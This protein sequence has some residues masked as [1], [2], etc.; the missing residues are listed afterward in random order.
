[1]SDS[2][3]ITWK[4]GK[5]WNIHRSILKTIFNDKLPIPEH[6]FSSRE[7]DVLLCLARMEKEGIQID[8]NID[9]KF[10]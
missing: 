4:D 1:M 9:A 6:W 5:R 8:N 7:L 10:R 2:I 3:L